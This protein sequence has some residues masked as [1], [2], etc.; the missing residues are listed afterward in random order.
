M[1]SRILKLCDEFTQN[2]V[3]KS[4]KHKTHKSTWPIKKNQR[5]NLVNSNITKYSIRWTAPM[6]NMTALALDHTSMPYKSILTLTTK[7][8]YIY[9]VIVSMIDHSILFFIYNTGSIATSLSNM[10]WPH[11]SLVIIVCRLYNNTTKH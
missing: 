11:W 7:M 10:T 9:M 2:Y 3:L 1:N 6:N 4:M 8:S 5:I